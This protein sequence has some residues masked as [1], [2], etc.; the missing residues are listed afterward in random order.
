[1][2][3]VIDK[4]LITN[5]SPRGQRFQ[6]RHLTPKEVKGVTPHLPSTVV[7]VHRHQTLEAVGQV[8]SGAG[9]LTHDRVHGGKLLGVALEHTAHTVF[10]LDQL[11]LVLFDLGGGAFG[12]LADHAG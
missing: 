12:L 5:I 8:V 9:A 10:E 3:S 2:L 6:T 4:E 11:F 1:M 7:G